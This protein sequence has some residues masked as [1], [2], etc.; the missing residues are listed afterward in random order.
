M[1]CSHNYYNLCLRFVWTI[2]GQ[3]GNYKIGS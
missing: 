3:E 1:S 2:V